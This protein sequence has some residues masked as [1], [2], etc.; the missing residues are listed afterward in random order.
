M[1]GQQ[2]L[3]GLRTECWGCSEH[4]AWLMS[5]FA[6]A[7]NYNRL[8]SR[9]RIW[10][11]QQESKDPMCLVS[12]VHY[13]FM[14]WGM[15]SWHTGQSLVELEYSC[16]LCATIYQFATID[17]LCNG[18]FLHDKVPYYKTKVI[19]SSCGHKHKNKFFVLHWPSM[20]PSKSNTSL[21]CG[22]TEV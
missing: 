18:F 22:T 13:G 16:W 20:S 5:I 19:S 15:F 11:Q 14:V 1:R 9:I 17:P 7:Q 12:T 2:R 8:V 6:E 3:A 4:I 10:C 21:G